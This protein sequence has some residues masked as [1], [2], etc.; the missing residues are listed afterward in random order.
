MMWLLAGYAI[1]VLMMGLRSHNR[2]S[3]AEHAAW[4]FL[5]PLAIVAVLAIG[6]VRLCGAVWKKSA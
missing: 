5:W 1:G 2:V 3:L 4:V 6:F